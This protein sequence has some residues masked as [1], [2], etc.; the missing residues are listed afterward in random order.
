MAGRGV[1]F[2]LSVERIDLGDGPEVVVGKIKVNAGP[3]AELVRVREAPYFRYGDRLEIE[4]SLEEPQALGD[5]DYRAYLADQGISLTMPF[6]QQVRL[7]DQGKG[8]IALENIYSLRRELS[9]GLDRA[10]PEPQASLSQALLLGIRGKLPEDTVEDFRSTGT[11]HMLAISGLHVGVV[12]AISLWVGAWIMGRRRQVYLL[13]P[14]SAI[15]LYALISGFSDPVERAAIMG[16]VFLVGLALGRPK[17][18]LP[19]LALAA[20]VMIGVKPQVLNQV[21]FQLSFTAMVGIALLVEREPRLRTRLDAFPV[22]PWA[23]WTGALIRPLGLLVAVSVAA[24]VATL[25]L[26]AFNFHRV[27]TLGIPAT[28]LTLPAL[29]ALLTT[30]AL[31]ALAGMANSTAGEVFGWFA[32]APSQYML[33]IVDL[34][35][36]VPGSTISVPRFSGFL[37]WVYYGVIGMLLLVPGGP[38]GL[39]VTARRSLQTAKENLQ[40]QRGTIPRI[41]I[42]FGAYIIVGLGLAAIASLLWFQVVTRPDGLLHV[43]FFDVGQGD[44]VF[45]VTPEGKQVLVDGGPHRLRAVRAVS[46][47]TGPFDRDL[48]MV[49]LTHPDEDHFRGLVEVVEKFD[50][51]TVLE[52]VGGSENPLYSEWSATLDRRGPERVRAR[53]GQVIVLDDSTWMEVLN[54]PGQPIVGTPSDRNNNGLV[55]R[56]THGE[57]SFLLTADIELETEQRLLRAGLPLDSDVLKVAHHGSSSSTST[58]FLSAVSPAAAVISAGLDNPFGHPRPDVIA[59]LNADPGA[60]STYITAERGDIEIITDGERLWVKT[61]R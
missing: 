50:V 22:P 52:G 7:L 57:I 15:W 23:A 19:V 30:S 17:S 42:P 32:W 26:I 39:L 3:T 9:D 35:S 38:A 47:R 10:M 11:S 55:L 28:I 44:S 20:A 25:P 13:L 41:H 1:E 5:F 31:A 48:D 61:S 2:V 37:V 21:S 36:K 45:L 51:D 14:L 8:N 18:I 6:P 43:Y 27:P 46:A 58:G 60:N 24:T 56:L 40:A 59:K 29:P 34:F 12:L 33:W 49:V 53:R 54:P 4:G 16:S